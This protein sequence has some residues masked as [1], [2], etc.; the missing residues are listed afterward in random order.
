MRRFD[1]SK[2]FRSA[3]YYAIGLAVALALIFFFSM[4]RQSSSKFQGVVESVQNSGLTK[5]SAQE[6]FDSA[7]SNSSFNVGDVLAT[8][9]NSGLDFR[10]DSGVG[11]HM[12]SDSLVAIREIQKKAVPDY[13]Y[14]DFTINLKKDAPVTVHGRTAYVK[15]K[16]ARLNLH[17]SAD[18]PPSIQ[19]VDGKA[20]VTDF[21][22][23][24]LPIKEL[25]GKP[26]RLESL[27]RLNYIWKLSDLYDLEG[28]YVRRKLTEPE[29]IAANFTV[30]WSG[31]GDKAFVQLSSTKNFESHLDYEASNGTHTF[32]KVF[33]KANFWRVSYDNVHWS[34]TKRFLVQPKVL[35]Q[36]QPTALGGKD[37]VPILYGLGTTE[38]SLKAAN[39]EA[40]G[41]VVEASADPTFKSDKSELYLVKDPQL[42]LHFEKPGVYFYRFRS[43]NRSQELSDWSETEKFTAF[44]PREPSIPR[45]LTKNHLEGGIGDQFHLSYES[46][47]P[48]E[49]E[50]VDAEGTTVGYFDSNH[51]T[52][53]PMV[54][55]RY[56][57]VATS[58]DRYG[59]SSLP[60]EAVEI[61][62]VPKVDLA[63][64]PT[65]ERSPAQTEEPPQAA[66]TKPSAPKP[67]EMDFRPPNHTYS[68]SR[69]GIRG[70]TARLQST[71]Q[72]LDNIEPPMA[73]GF[74]LQYMGWWDHAGLEAYVKRQVIPVNT[75][76]HETNFLDTE[77]RYHYRF[78]L[79]PPLPF[80]TEMQGSL[81]FG[82]EF[83]RNSGQ[84]FS[85]GWDLTTLGLAVEFPVFEHWSAGGEFVFGMGSDISN[86][87][88]M[89][90]HVTRYWSRKWSSQFGYILH[91]FEAG[92]PGTTPYGTL[93]YREGYT[94]L[95]M[96][97]DYHF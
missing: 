76:A 87:Y 57:A 67:E 82:H 41:F 10:I 20:E 70:F 90:G 56:L 16:G 38:I 84:S 55:G 61:R 42:R 51:A 88:E 37:K 93:P 35:K 49:I 18:K 7:T 39:I 33:S 50:V 40:T 59:R 3:I 30:A 74:G 25:P 45:L 80:V 71:D 95:Y 69:F 97:L 26:I 72:Y 78:S 83:F 17:V 22:V 46:R 73:T 21:M 29:M 81:F 48:I 96:T 65:L 64:I 8:A 68:E 32:E 1:R 85:S 91:L 23:G 24:T 44:V 4:W 75:S 13:Q 86:K 89:S 92:S 94:E 62:V 54:S 11:V 34:E 60:S 28:F 27:D 77:V 36:G 58:K 52:F 9:Q 15:T 43:F 66:E 63:Q 5:R 14:G 47:D 6:I 19:L 53:I 2:S 12:D 31:P 79:P